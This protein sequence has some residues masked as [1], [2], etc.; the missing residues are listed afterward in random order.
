MFSPE[1]WPVI[2]NGAHEVT[3]S[4]FAGVFVESATGQGDV[5]VRFIEYTAVQPAETWS[6]TSN[7]PKILRIVE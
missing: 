2:P 7:L 6:L 1:E 5:W 3:V 4:N